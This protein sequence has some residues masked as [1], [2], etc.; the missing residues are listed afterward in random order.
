METISLQHGVARALPPS[1]TS[2]VF[3][4]LRSQICPLLFCFVTNGNVVQASQ[5]V[6][7]MLNESM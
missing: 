7:F 5:W 3:L 6:C 1:N 4:D 2:P